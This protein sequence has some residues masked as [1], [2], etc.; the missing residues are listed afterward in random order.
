M[1]GHESQRER[2]SEQTDEN[3]QA[4]ANSSPLPESPDASSSRFDQTRSLESSSGFG[5]IQVGHGQAREDDARYRKSANGRAKTAAY[6]RSGAGRPAQARFGAHRNG[7]ETAEK[8]RAAQAEFD[9]VWK[10]CARTEQAA[11]MDW[12]K[13]FVCFAST[14]GS[15]L[16]V[17]PVMDDAGN[18]KALPAGR[19]RIFAPASATCCS[20]FPG[21]G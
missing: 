20:S 18:V 17:N 19:S 7:R 14:S 8:Q 3:E 6:R 5:Q 12:T 10:K 4:H 21:P 2:P 16:R 15:I 1:P 11:E 9:A 13:H